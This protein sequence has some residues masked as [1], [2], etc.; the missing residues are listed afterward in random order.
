[1]NHETV[2]LILAFLDGKKTYGCVL[3]LM[4]YSAGAKL[5]WYSLDATIVTALIA[6]CIASLRAS[7]KSKDDT[8]GN[9]Q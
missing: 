1:M 4:A 9:G 8:A 6:T 5:G 2:K 3:L 7:N